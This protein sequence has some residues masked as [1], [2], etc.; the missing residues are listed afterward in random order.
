[1]KEGW[2]IK[3]LSEVC[4]KIFA[5]GDKPINYSKIKTNKN[6]I[7]IYANGVKD[8]GLYGYTN[9]A[10][11]IKPSITISA[12]GTIGYTEIRQHPF[13]PIVRLIVLIPIDNII[14]LEFLK[15]IV[16][17]TNFSNSGT[18]IPQLT[19]PM[20]KNYLLPMPPLP[21]Q[22]RIVKIL[23]KAFAAID[24][25]VANTQKNLRNSKE[26]FDSYLNK[27]FSSPGKDWE[28]K[29]L[30]EC[31]KLKSGDGLTAKNM[32]QEGNIPVY[33]G[34]GIAGY[35]NEY[36]L[37]GSNVIVGRVGALCGNVRC[38][39]ENI[40]LTDN[41]FKVIDIKYDF[42][43]SFLTYLLNFKDLKRFARQAAQPVI[44]NS[45]LQYV[46]LNFPNSIEEQKQIVKK[47]D[48]LLSETKKLESIYQQKLKDLEE[49]KKS[50]LQKAFE[51]EL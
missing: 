30:Y 8:K 23:D 22:K 26:L 43:N 36:N 44:S 50:I 51:G 42:D 35:H 39:N 9:Y 46:I 31:F 41:A 2:E 40:W 15:Y 28:E 1:M 24:K 20:V 6:K 21:E 13:F 47:L 34:N 4:E 18:S 3:K 5:G 33:G 11:V 29:K 12:R 17:Y 7:P 32:N 49:L 38:I 16:E 14:N 19:V 27:I 48:D 45:S 10:K 25:A 37:S